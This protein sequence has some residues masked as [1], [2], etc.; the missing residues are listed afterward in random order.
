[1]LTG[2]AFHLAIDPMVCL[3]GADT[4]TGVQYQGTTQ[5]YD[6]VSEWICTT[7]RRR[8]G[9]WTRRVLLPGELERRYGIND[10]T[11]SRRP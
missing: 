7:C 4:F 5:D 6:G 3:C 8:Y 10:Q 1:M 11:P 9:R 2:A